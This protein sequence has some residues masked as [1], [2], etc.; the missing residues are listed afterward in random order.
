MKEHYKNLT[1]SRYSSVDGTDAILVTGRPAPDVIEQLF[2][3][4]SNGLLLRRVI[5]TTTSLGN[6][7]EQVDYAD[8]HDVSGVKVPFQVRYATWNDV[9]TEKFTDVKLNTP[10]DDAQFA[11]PAGR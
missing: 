1:V 8:Y 9:V 10:I 3:D 7:L 2:F 11:K 4:K 6:L 5:Q